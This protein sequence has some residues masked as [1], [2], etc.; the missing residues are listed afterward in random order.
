MRAS[1]RAGYLPH[2]VEDLRTPWVQMGS[3]MLVEGKFMV[4]DGVGTAAYP[5]GDGLQP[6][7][8]VFNDDLIVFGSIC[9]G[10]DCANGESF[11]YCTQKFKE[12]NPQIC[13]EDTSTGSYPDN[14]WKIQINDTSNGGASFFTIWDSDAGV[15]PFSIEAGAPAHALYVED[16]GSVGLGTGSPSMELDIVDGDTP[17]VRLTQNGT[18]GWDPQ[19]WDVAGNETSFFIRDVT[20]DSQLPF[21]IQS[22]TPGDTLTMKSAGYVGVGTWEPAAKLHVTRGGE[23]AIADDPV[24]A[25]THTEASSDNALLLLQGG[26]DGETGIVF[27][28]VDDENIGSLKYDNDND[29]MIF[30]TGNTDRMEI[31][32]AG[33][34]G[35]GASPDASYKLRVNG[36]VRAE[37]GFSEGSSREVKENIADLGV[38]EA[39]AAL[40][41]LAPVAFNYKEDAGEERI[42]FIAEDVPELVA[43]S[44]RKGVYVM[45]IVAVLTKVVQTQQILIDELKRENEGMQARVAALEGKALNR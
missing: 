38:E 45:D 3:F 22:G 26:S 9:V 28:D 13:F 43:A 18:G 35:V 40:Q 16:S 36:V 32:S 30:R 10:L 8:D 11:G 7:D 5:G 15:R 19:T 31:S 2:F 41:E 27:G 6:E 21:R 14:D 25:F 12:N 42:G 34:V 39:V 1:C 20:N 33:D 24:A 29:A 17:T 4:D 44:D 23:A 37:N